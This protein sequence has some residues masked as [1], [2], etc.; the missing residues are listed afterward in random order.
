MDDPSG[1]ITLD[2]ID[3]FF[4]QTHYYATYLTPSELLRRI[5]G[6]PHAAH[7]VEKFEWVFK[8]NF[9][10]FVRRSDN[11]V[12]SGLYPA[13]YLRGLDARMFIN[14][15]NYLDLEL[16]DWNTLDRKGKETVAEAY[17]VTLAESSIQHWFPYGS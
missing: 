9:S 1:T 15:W 11:L 8:Q 2:D 14:F 12:L 3:Q 17:R 4:I 10:S 7:V 16:H 6:H 13:L 5:V